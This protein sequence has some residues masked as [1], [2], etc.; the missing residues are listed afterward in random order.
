MLHNKLTEM[1]LLKIMFY[2][3]MTVF[4]FGMITMIGIKTLKLVPDAIIIPALLLSAI[5]ILVC[6]LGIGNLEQS[7]KSGGESAD[8]KS[9][10]K[11]ED[12][13]MA[14]RA[15]T[16]LETPKPD[17]INLYPKDISGGEVPKAVRGIKS[18][19]LETPR[20]LSQPDKGIGTPKPYSKQGAG[21]CV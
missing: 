5:G 7:L 10:Q 4:V 17:S 15:R 13:G 19:V 8:G 3:S 1:K 21:M 20:Q 12:S 2:G 9:R 11:P 6:G 18:G 16:P 14:G